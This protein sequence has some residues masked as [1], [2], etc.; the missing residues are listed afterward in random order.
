MCD[1]LTWIGLLFVFA[2][3]GIMPFNCDRSLIRYWIYRHFILVCNSNRCTTAAN[4]IYMWFIC[5]ISD[6]ESFVLIYSSEIIRTDIKNYKLC[7]S[8]QQQQ[9]LQIKIFVL[10][11]ANGRSIGHMCT[12]TQRKRVNKSDPEFMHVSIACYKFCIM[13]LKNVTQYALFTAVHSC[14]SHA[15]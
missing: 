6:K 12:S 13:N 2:M 4:F 14:L 7:R 5:D 15:K 8:L 1:F 3:Y 9:Y 11:F 10:S